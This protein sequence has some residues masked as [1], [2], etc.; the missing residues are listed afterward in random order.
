MTIR[1]QAPDGS[2]VQFPDGT[3]SITIDRA[4]TE[5]FGGGA[6]AAAVSTPA[7]DAL[8]DVAK[9]AGS[10]VLKGVAGVATLPQTMHDF[11]GGV[12][13]FAAEQTVGRVINAI[14]SGGSDFSPAPHPE[15]SD[16]L[17]DRL[18]S[19]PRQ[20]D[21][22]SAIDR[23]GLIHKPETT[24]GRYAE[25]VGEFL[26]MSLA[27]PGSWMRNATAFGVVP[28]LTSEAAGQYA[29]G[30]GYEEPA[31]IFGA[32]AGG[33]GGALSGKAMAGVKN[34]G[35]TNAA[36]Q[37][38]AAVTGQPRVAAGAVRRVADSIAEDGLTPA[39][40]R[41]KASE[42]GPEAM[43]MDMGRQLGGRAEAIAAQP[44]RG[45]NAVLD[46]VEGRTGQ[47][48]GNTAAR[49]KQ[50]LDDVMGTSPNMVETQ[51]RVER[52][53]D[54]LASPQYKRVM[55][56]HPAI[57]DDG[58][59]KL[60]ERP[61]IRQ[62]ML[63]AYSL[64]KNY[65]EEVKNLFQK[66]PPSASRML[67][68]HRDGHDIKPSL[69]FWDYVK[70]SIDARIERLE[71][72]GGI[73]RLNSKEIADMG[74]L[75]AAK[76]ALLKH[77]DEVTSGEYALARKLSATKF[78]VRDAADFGRKAFQNGLL[79]EQF[80]AR[81]NDM[82]LPEQTM[83]KAAMRREIERVIDT[84]RN[85]GAAARRFLDTEQNGQKI[86]AIFGRD[87]LAEIEKRIA[88]ETHFQNIKTNVANNSRTAVRGELIK[89]TA[90]PSADNALQTSVTGL[91][92][93]A[94]RG[95][96]NY[97]RNQG[98]SRTREGIA[99]LLTTKGPEMQRLIEILSNLGTTR[100]ANARPIQLPLSLAPNALLT[101][102][103]WS[104][105]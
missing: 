50:T 16:T 7:P 76:N 81:I 58:L 73:E 46:A 5:A 15:K 53:V 77:L 92:H 69:Q 56:E 61:V 101:A 21:V 38:I 41:A 87:A 33:L 29:E 91:V 103:K 51:K 105:R 65:G 96:L 1:V 43:L 35:A 26:P 17:L 34:Y 36:G 98:M 63:D 86:A 10:G 89:D 54:T 27:G 66:A 79:P 93:A 6:P 90:T 72:K 22:V 84:A 12:S 52:V 4:M 97:V 83:V 31:R 99:D 8:T 70:K 20:Q 24:A 80:T 2:M 32:L 44:G 49:V 39:A 11:L 60:S 19:L 55:S 78:E 25:T 95:G 23:A 14:K 67:S 40:V 62:A 64:A 30:S 48:G 74:G 42:L 3:D 9:S 102:P 37:E 75:V 57:W 28:G 85:D 82:S 47:F 18:P 94:G 100:A 88:A 13:G 104:E 68:I 71:G 59:Q 45:Q